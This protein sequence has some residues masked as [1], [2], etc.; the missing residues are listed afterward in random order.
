MSKYRTHKVYEER[1]N[2]YVNNHHINQVRAFDENATPIVLAPEPVSKDRLK[3]K[4]KNRQQDLSQQLEVVAAVDGAEPAMVLRPSWKINT[5]YKVATHPTYRI[6]V[7]GL[8][9]G[10]ER[11]SL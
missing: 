5:E 7:S 1:Y 11:D 8:N 10:F 6:R 3:N 4:Q 2:S 9:K